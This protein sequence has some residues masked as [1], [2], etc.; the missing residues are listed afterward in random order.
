MGLP[1]VPCQDSPLALEELW[2][3]VAAQVMRFSTALTQ[4]TVCN[5]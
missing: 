5:S 4:Q 2:D 1:G 3:D